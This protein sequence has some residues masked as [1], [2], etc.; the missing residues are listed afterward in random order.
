MGK[1]RTRLLIID[2]APTN[3]A[4]LGEGLKSEFQLAVATNG[5]TGLKLA[6][7]EP[8]PHLILLDI[9][10]PGMDGYEVC[11][12]LKSDPATK[13]I[14]VIF[15]TSRSDVEDETRGLQIGA[16]DYITKPFNLDIVR[17]RIQTHLELQQRTRELRRALSELEIRNQFIRQTFGRYLSDEIVH[18]ILEKP[19]GLRLG[20]ETREVTVLMADLRG[21]TAICE[22]L[23]AE[24]VVG[25]INIFLGAMTEIIVGHN[26]TID[27]FLGD[28][29]L[30][31]FGAPVKRENDAQ[32]AVACALEM[33]RAM[34]EVNRKNAKRGYPEVSMGI[35]IHTSQLIVGNIGSK[36]RIKYGVVGHGVNLTAR[37][38]SSTVGGQVLISEKTRE[39]CGD[40]LRIDSR[41]EILPKGV[42][43]PLAIYEIGG[44]GGEF[45]I[46][47]PPKEEGELK[48]LQP[49]LA[50]RYAPLL[51]K[52]G[53]G[54]TSDGTLLAVAQPRA[55]LQSAE[56]LA[57]LSNLKISLLDEDGQE[58]VSGLY[59][60]VIRELSSSPG[61]YRIH[62][63][64]V[65][66]EARHFFAAHIR[67]GKN[68]Q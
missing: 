46:H 47:L 29:I 10:M 41:M 20:G 67:G 61:Q 11:R 55:D 39:F 64:S 33:Q 50:V 42:Q 37:I 36:K 19:E 40:L 4:I 5:T 2:D 25:L 62:F 13:N 32:H 16:V 49:P 21:F 9:V 3:I 28:A 59:A 63:T 17:A 48:P 44:I 27:E 43:E 68:A 57:S 34:A 15:I 6:R 30:A 8:R 60:K 38:E 26:G 56:P 51:G 18:E 35:G 22:K 45:K 58:A 12:T 7:G 23:P 53:L 31:I 1:N 65:S 14:P 54:E 66:A 24:D 52:H